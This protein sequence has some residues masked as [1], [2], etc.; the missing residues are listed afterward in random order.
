[1]YHST[2]SISR[3]RSHLEAIDILRG[4]DEDEYNIDEGFFA[5]E[6]ICES[7]ISNQGIARNLANTYISGFMHSIRSKL[8]DK[9]IAEPELETL[10][11]SIQALQTNSFSNDHELKPVRLEIASRL[12]DLYYEGYSKEE[13]LREISKLIESKEKD[14]GGGT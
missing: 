9:G 13:K 1:M 3:A 10:F 4:N 5:L 11:R 6:E 7:D 2:S 14:R 12:I 8:S